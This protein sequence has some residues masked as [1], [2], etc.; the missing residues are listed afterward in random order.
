VHTPE[1]AIVLKRADSATAAAVLAAP[2]VHDGQ[3]LHDRG[4]R[5]MAPW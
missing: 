1:C 2:L 5:C 3:Q 4:G